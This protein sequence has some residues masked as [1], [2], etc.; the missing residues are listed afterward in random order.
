MPI[1]DA[2]EE[3]EIPEIDLKEI[4]KEVLEEYIES[5][6]DTVTSVYLKMLNVHYPM[7]DLNQRK[8]SYIRN[9]SQ[10]S[11]LDFYV[12][13]SPARNDETE[14]FVLNRILYT[15]VKNNQWSSYII[16][17]ND[18][19]DLHMTVNQYLQR[20]RATTQPSDD[21]ITN[22]HFALKNAEDNNLVMLYVGNSGLL[23]T[24]TKK[25]VE[26]YIKKL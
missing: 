12:L 25:L 1:D 9:A 13:N 3:L 23:V 19:A 11:E 10:Y 14:R 26:F 8:L 16:R 7:S 2:L 22:K 21:I 24:P 4:A 17:K 18:I 6:L 15:S 20:S 5:S